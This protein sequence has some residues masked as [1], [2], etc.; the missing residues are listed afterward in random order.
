MLF[1]RRTAHIAVAM[2]S[3]GGVA[4]GWSTPALATSAHKGDSHRNAHGASLLLCPR[5][6]RASQA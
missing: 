1:T 6:H 2:V 4:I 3:V 5:S